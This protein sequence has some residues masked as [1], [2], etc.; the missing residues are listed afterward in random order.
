MVASLAEKVRQKEGLYILSGI[1]MLTFLASR[2]SKNHG[3]QS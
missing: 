1:S 3:T 2:L